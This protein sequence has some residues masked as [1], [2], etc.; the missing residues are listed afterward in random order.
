MKNKKEKFD[1]CLSMVTTWT[2]KAQKTANNFMKVKGETIR[3]NSTFRVETKEMLDELLN[4]KKSTIRVFKKKHIRVINLALMKIQ[5]EQCN[6]KL[7]SF[8]FEI[9]K[10]GYGGNKVVVIRK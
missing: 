5:R 1:S 3:F 10:E 4:M 9:F 2:D 8:N 7:L 6:Y